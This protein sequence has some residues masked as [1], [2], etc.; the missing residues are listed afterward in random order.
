M[1][2]TYTQFI[3][4]LVIAS[5][6]TVAVGCEKIAETPESSNN[7]PKIESSNTEKPKS[8]T[9]EPP[10]DIAKRKEQFA[11]MLESM[12][13]VAS[14][15]TSTKGPEYDY[16]FNFPSSNW[17][18]I[19]HGAGDRK[20]SV[21]LLRLKDSGIKILLSAGGVKEAP[22]F[23]KSVQMVYDSSVKKNPEATREWK[24]GNFTI[25][26]SFIGFIDDRHGEVTISAFSPVCT[27]EFNIASVN[28]D[29]D[30]L[31]KIADSSVE[32][33]IQKNPSGG[34]PLR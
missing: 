1:N 29:R 7:S 18:K 12:Y 27:L 26:R 3:R 6:L 34:F 10:I 25:R 2:K 16:K 8:T 14:L 22:E 20:S 28:L 33:F 23:V 4:T 17:E 9:S 31:F 21:W 11:Q 15:A 5:C 24:V 30:E 32:S 13:A 19:S